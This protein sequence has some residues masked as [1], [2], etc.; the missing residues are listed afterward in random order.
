MVRLLLGMVVGAAA[1]ALYMSRSS[2]MATSARALGR[3]DELSTA[4]DNVVADP[5][6]NAGDGTP[7]RNA[8]TRV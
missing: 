3:I 1:A 2:S 6:L 5:P 7:S 8:T 4:E